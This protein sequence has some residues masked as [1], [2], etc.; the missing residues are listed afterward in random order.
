MKLFN[1]A[2]AYTDYDA[3]L[4]TDHGN[5]DTAG[6]PPLPE[7]TV[8]DQRTQRRVEHWVRSFVVD[9]EE[10]RGETMAFIN[11]GIGQFA[12]VLKVLRDHFRENVTSLAFSGN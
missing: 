8:E 9:Q 2:S 11:E 4:L 5:Q 3:S 12:P 1:L 10:K 6:A 7:L